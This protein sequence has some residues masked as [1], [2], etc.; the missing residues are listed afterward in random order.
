M[1]ETGETDHAKTMYMWKRVTE[2]INQILAF[3][4]LISYILPYKINA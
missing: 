3:I 4:M 2:I 1:L